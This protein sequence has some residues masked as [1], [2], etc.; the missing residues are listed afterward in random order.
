MAFVVVEGAAKK[1]KKMKC[2]DKKYC[3]CYHQNLYCPDSCPITCVV[4]CVS[5]QPVSTLPPPPPSPLKV[6]RRSPPPP[7]KTYP[8]P[9]LTP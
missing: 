5:C 7:P 1:H 3:S 9:P 6:R 4:D 2:Q 8:S